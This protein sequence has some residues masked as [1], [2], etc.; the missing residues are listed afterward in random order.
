MAS[1]RVHQFHSGSAVGDAI[2]NGMFL[3]RDALRARGIESDI[4]VEGRDPRL[5]DELRLLG[6][7][8]PQ[9]DDILLIHHSMGHDVM[10]FL[11]GLK[12]RKILVYHNI[13][14]PKFFAGSRGWQ[15]YSV[16]GYDQLSTLKEMVMHAIAD[17]DYN[18]EELKRRGFDDVTTIPLLRDFKAVRHQPFNQRHQ[19]FD[20]PAYH[21]IFVGRIA[22]NKGQIELVEFMAAYSDSFDYPLKLTLIGHS[23]H[24][25]TGYGDRI[26]GLIA[27]YG[28]EDRIALV[29]HISDEDLYGYYR[30]ADAYVS[31][32]QHEGF[33]VPLVEAM[34]FDLPIVAYDT[35]A[36][37]STLGGS[38]V[39]IP[40]TRP[41]TIAR[42]LAPVLM[43]R[44]TRRRV[45]RGQ[46]RRLE[47][48]D[49]DHLTDQLIATLSP[50]LQ[51]GEQFPAPATDRLDTGLRD[52]ERHYAVQGP[53]ETS[54]SLAIVN[55]SLAIG[56][57]GIEN[58]S[59]SVVP[60][61]GQGEYAF[62]AEQAASYADLQRLLKPSPQQPET[63]AVTIR[64]TYPPRPGGMQGDYRLMNFFWEETEVP[65]KTIDLMERHLDG[66]LVASVFG[67]NILRNSG[68]SRPVAVIGCGIDHHAV[69][70]EMPTRAAKI[71]RN[72]RFLHVSSG[73][74]R[75]GIEEL[76]LAYMTAFTIADAVELV[77]KT[78][79]NETN[80]VRVLYERII[81][82]RPNAPV[83]N[84]IAASMLDADIQDLYAS[85]DAVVLPTRGEGFNL[86]AAEAMIA[87]VPV[88]VTGFSA[89]MDFC[90]DDSA[91]LI[92]FD[93]EP[94][95]SHVRSSNSMWVRP[96]PIELSVAMRRLYD[97]PPSVAAERDKKRLE[98]FETASS[99]TW[100][101]SA[102][103]TDHFVDTLMTDAPSKPR[104]KVAWIS[105]WN[106]KC[107]IA[108]YSEFL[109]PN[110]S[111]SATDVTIFATLEEPNTPDSAN[112]V[113]AWS[114]SSDADSLR[115][116]TERIV[117]DGFDAVVIQHN[118]GFFS[119]RALSQA[120]SYL[121]SKGLDSYIF[122]HRTEVLVRN[123]QEQS[124]SSIADTLRGATRLIVHSAAD[125]NRLKS[126]GLIDNVVQIPHGLPIAPAFDPAMVKRFL[127]MREAFPLI[128]SYGFLLPHKGISELIMAF[129][130]LRADHPNAKLLLLN[131]EYP[132]PQS[133]DEARLCR[134]LIGDLGL[135][136]SVVLITDYM[137]NEDVTLMLHAADAIV[138]PYQDTEESASGAVR[139]GL[140]AL[141]PVAVTPLPIFK[142]VAEYCYTLPGTSAFQIADGLRALINDAETQRTLIARQ[143][144]W[145]DDVNWEQIG[146][147]LTG[148]M[149]GLH[150]DTRE[151]QIAPD[152]PEPKPR[153]TAVSR[154][155]PADVLSH[156]S[157]VPFVRLACQRILGRDPT[158]VEHAAVAE[159]RQGRL[160]RDAFLARLTDEAETLR[161][162]GDLARTEVVNFDDSAVLGDEAFV[163]ALY[164]RI[165]G[166]EGDAGGV[167]SHVERLSD[168]SATR[169][170]LVADF[171][172][173]DEFLNNDRIVSVVGE[174]RSPAG[175]KSS[176]A[177]ADMA[178]TQ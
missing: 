45:I 94:S 13:T 73:L 104:L 81:G 148:M 14:P 55:R 157:E 87:G 143:K 93:F 120:V 145:L 26:R 77:I 51:P 39:R 63:T 169:A 130:L 18:A 140:A 144:A 11:V 149:V 172:Q 49:V 142:D 74:A 27:R 133:A 12:C 121:T 151:V 21:L 89:H 154:A 78:Y 90:D 88:V 115:E 30:A 64:N 139:F 82:H 113:R 105:T 3:I 167:A 57:D 4:Y 173:S 147:R 136:E 9:P 114:M 118:F 59:A 117:D 23:H 46:R 165:L 66:V 76:L 107:G 158:D 56:L 41:D 111:A 86:P 70:T 177:T 83:V 2:T 162:Q 58:S 150:N 48:F 84:V 92:G 141:R 156:L 128:A 15:E 132:A 47:D 164:T 112:V 161:A 69:P 80:V 122:F 40:D 163:K 137:D 96:R 44:E 116:L 8:E 95:E 54:Y 138:Y 126:Y 135:E 61:E 7:F 79:D 176:R 19:H 42:A 31:L 171:L 24:D 52:A 127:G 38:G 34:A 36:I 17:S 125:V 108:S 62:D 99:L 35:A 103:K 72:F 20:E 106:T 10:P 100:A 152:Y 175:E 75:K 170:D 134:K 129:G 91:W 98:A 71:S 159:L 32:S 119:M 174:I 153:R 6:Q 101:R 25:G 50:L 22:G 33:G 109:A 68:L 97:A 29:G 131:G 168:G 155:D 123:G 28:L 102:Q 60:M 16:K 160:S 53:C 5:S 110:L 65:R 146:K 166:R 37:S 178:T 124:I 85:A 43:S 1:V 67:R